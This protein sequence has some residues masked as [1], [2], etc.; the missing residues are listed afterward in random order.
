[1][2]SRSFQA[3]VTGQRQVSPG[4]FVLSLKSLSEAPEPRAGQFYMLG[5]GDGYDPLLKRPF[6][7]FGYEG[8]II[9]ILYAVRG[10]G[11][12]LLSTLK[13]GAVI[14]VLGPL[15]NGYPAPRRGSDPLIIAGG[16]AIASVYPLIM[17]LKKKC[18]VVYGARSL[19]ELLMVEDIT[20]AARE[21]HTCTEDGSCGAHGNVIDVLGSLDLAPST[22]IYACGPRG[23]VDAVQAFAKARGL[24]G[25]VS[26]EEFMACGIGAC[27]GCVCKTAHGYKRV[28]KE[29]PVFPLDEVIM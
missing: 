16:T 8:G 23:L 1:M 27:M 10:R 7:M 3:E 14:P 2:E 17:Q 26:L 18:R 29:G 22:M 19:A 15:G 4:Q 6:C 9:R 28:C 21:V 13:P 20:A 25:V 24:A 12:R 5:V 11:T